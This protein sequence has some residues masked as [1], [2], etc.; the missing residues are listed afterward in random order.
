MGRFHGHPP[1]S[2]DVCI[3]SD[4]SRNYTEVI[5]ANKNVLT[6]QKVSNEAGFNAHMLVYVKRDITLMMRFYSELYLSRYAKDIINEQKLTNKAD[7]QIARKILSM[8]VPVLLPGD[9]YKRM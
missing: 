9:T 5:F 2:R 3:F 6:R 7:I 8:W 1:L 4:P